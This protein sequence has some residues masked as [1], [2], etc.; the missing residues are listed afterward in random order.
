MTSNILVLNTRQSANQPMIVFGEGGSTTSFN[1]TYE[2]NTQSAYSCGL[3]Y[4]NEGFIFGGSSYKTQI[5]R[6]E[7]CGLNRVGDLEFDFY[8]G[9]CTNYID[10]QI[11]LCFSNTDNYKLCRKSSQP[12]GQFELVADCEH[13]HIDIRIASSEGT[14]EVICISVSFILRATDSCRWS[15]CSY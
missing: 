1:F 13:K 6:I 9:A 15:P 2:R 4:R 5:S 8:A 14:L 3:I 12:L 7:N 11:F 10:E